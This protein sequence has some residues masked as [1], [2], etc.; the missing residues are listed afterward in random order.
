M[1]SEKS[2]FNINHNAEQGHGREYE[3]DDQELNEAM[4]Q[5][6]DIAQDYGLDPYPT[7]F[8]V[9]PANIIYQVGA[10]GIP[11]KFTH[12]TYGRQ[13]RQSKTMYDHGMSK[14]YELVI[15]SNPS[16]AYLLENNP[17]TENKFIMAH[18]FGH[19][20]FFK[21]NMMFENTRRDMP[22]A[23]ARQA[24]RIDKYSDQYGE[25]EVEKLLDATL[26]L[27]WNIDPYLIERPSKD[28]ELDAW[29][30]RAEDK[31]KPVEKPA[32]RFSDLFEF[33]DR[34]APPSSTAQQLGR[35]ALMMM[36]PE[37]DRDLLGF[38][39]NHAPYLED[40]QRDT[41]DI[42]RQESLYFYPQMRTKVMNEGWAAY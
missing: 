5:I 18:V 14:I 40:W 31:L 15:N 34:N 1:A 22:E 39:R 16:Q 32:S 12:W 11:G 30:K 42:V 23:V 25:L 3:N 6:W 10:Y 2:P 13:Y 29:R 24:E 36:P 9:A 28:E 20:D 35:R 4:R 41:I 26:A 17:P 37:P 33:E 8:D 38:I 7:H 21:N 19:T 27:Q